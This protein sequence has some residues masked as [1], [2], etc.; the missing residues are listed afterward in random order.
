MADENAKLVDCHYEKKDWRACKDEVC[1][2]PFM[3]QTQIRPKSWNAKTHWK[4]GADGA[5]QAVLEGPGQRQ[6]DGH[7][8][9]REV[10]GGRPPPFTVIIIL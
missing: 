7:E 8:G 3:V 6:A 1:G 2:I 5:V 4:R 10:A 9:R